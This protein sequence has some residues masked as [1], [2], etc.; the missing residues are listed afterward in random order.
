[1]GDTHTTPAPQPE[2]SPEQPPQPQPQPQPPP[3]PP[4]HPLQNEQLGPK[5]ITG[6]G[7]RSGHLYGVM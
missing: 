5:V 1:M 4:R 7:R 3:Q 2:P 6:I